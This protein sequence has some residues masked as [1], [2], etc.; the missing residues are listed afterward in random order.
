[1]ASHC[2]IEEVV[3]TPDL[4]AYD[5]QLGDLLVKGCDGDTKLFLTAV[6]G[7]LKRKTNFSAKGSEDPSKR[8]IES[9]KQV[10]DPCIA[11]G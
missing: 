9:W 4:A 5:K 11:H 10:R 1:M 7:F 3:D 2:V 6:F 8:I